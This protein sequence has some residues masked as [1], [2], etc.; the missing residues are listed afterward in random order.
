MKCLDAKIAQLTG[1]F[2]AKLGWLVGQMYSR[3][4]TED[5][6]REVLANKLKQ[7]LQDTALWI[8]DQKITAL[9]KAYVA[10]QIEHP[11]TKM[12]KIAITKA[13]AG[14]PTRKQ[15]VLD[16][17]NKIILETLGKDNEALYTKLKKRLE[18]DAGLSSIL[19]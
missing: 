7:A 18:N 2:Q 5:F 13:L 1:T 16:Q 11:G 8:D 17:T 12:S 15:L 4:G 19:K 6:A 14:V 9:E 10:Y 3:V